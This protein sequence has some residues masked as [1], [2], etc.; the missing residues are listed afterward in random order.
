MP[1][2]SGPHAPSFPTTHDAVEAAVAL[3]SNRIAFDRDLAAAA[4]AKLNADIRI[5]WARNAPT[6]AL[7][8]ALATML[9]EAP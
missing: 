2:P 1:A 3:V 5:R 6:R 4:L 9:S 7:R 8:D